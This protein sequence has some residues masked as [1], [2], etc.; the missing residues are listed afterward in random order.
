[1]SQIDRVTRLRN[2]MLGVAATNLALGG[3]GAA[4]F[5]FL[6]RTMGFSAFSA[7]AW[8]VCY[9]ALGLLMPARPFRSMQAG[10]MIL[11]VEGVGL[12]W[13]A[14]DSGAGLPFLGMAARIA[15]FVLLCAAFSAARAAREEASENAL[16]AQ[17]RVVARV[18][19]ERKAQDA[20]E[21]SRQRVLAEEE[22][23]R[24][25]Q[26]AAQAKAGTAQ[27]RA[28]VRSVAGVTSNVDAA[29]GLLRW[30]A[31]SLALDTTMLR[32]EIE[33]ADTTSVAYDALRKIVVRRL[34]SDPP[35]DAQIM[36][37]IVPQ[38]GMIPAPVIRVFSTTRIAFPPESR[39][40]GTA[41]LEIV[42]ALGALLVE[43]ASKVEM[44]EATMR[45]VRST[46]PPARFNT[47][48]ELA[49]HD[50]QYK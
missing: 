1:M 42:R 37:D 18:S 31:K 39:P 34:P 25:V 13:N 27:A 26:A 33:Q 4:G 23:I 20:D 12:V 17:R 7:F 43:R 11:V 16:R 19:T 28:K 32:L 40:A 45:F 44:D 48:K 14:Q 36:M 35:W 41:R 30:V 5:E 10:V 2:V 21:V 49:D 9:G 3:L 24:R 50:S 38:E 8:G 15:C 47:A 46:A 29:A 22:R 6:S